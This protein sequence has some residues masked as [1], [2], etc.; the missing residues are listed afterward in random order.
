MDKGKKYF[1]KS[2]KGNYAKGPYKP[3]GAYLKIN[4]GQSYTEKF[5]QQNFALWSIGKN[6]NLRKLWYDRYEL[7]FQILNNGRW[8]LATKRINKKEKNG[9]DDAG[10]TGKNVSKEKA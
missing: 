10:R 6:G 1:I 7:V 9:T 5:I 3:L 2:V 4:V 8:Q